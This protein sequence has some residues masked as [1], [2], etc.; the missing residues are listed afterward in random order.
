MISRKLFWK[1]RKPKTIFFFKTCVNIYIHK[2]CKFFYSSLFIFDFTK[3][4][5]LKSR[6]QLILVLIHT[7]SPFRQRHR[8]LSWFIIPPSIY[9][10]FF[11]QDHRTRT[12]L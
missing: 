2:I 9:F 4:V 12:L 11:F 7:Q 5:N 8:N 6:S 3:H 10:L 1:D